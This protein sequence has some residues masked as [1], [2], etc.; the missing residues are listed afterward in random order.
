MK[1]LVTLFPFVLLSITSAN[2]THRVVGGIDAYPHEFPYQISIQYNGTHHCGG[3][4]LNEYYILTAA[5]CAKPANATLVIAGGH[6]LQHFNGHEQVRR[7]EEFINHEEATDEVGPY[8]IALIKVTEPFV[9]NEFVQPIA[10][11][12]SRGY[13]SEDAVLSGWG[14]TSQDL[15]PIYPEVLQVGSLL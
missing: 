15:D 4:I 12:K 5:H 7:I 13:P 3:S 6:N 1:L 10:L 8:D 14:S 2:P 11:P 9:L